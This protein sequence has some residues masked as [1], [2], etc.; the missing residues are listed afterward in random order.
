MPRHYPAELRRRTCERMLAGAAVKDLVEELGI[1]PK[2]LYRWR[3]QA[4]IDAGRDGERRASRP[5]RSSK[6]AAAS[7]NSRPS[8][9][10]SG[11]PAPC[12]RRAVGTQKEVPGCPRAEQPGLLRTPGLPDR[13]SGR[14]SY[15]EIKYRMPTSEIRRLL[16]SDAIADIHARSRGTYGMLRI[17]AALEIEQRLIVNKK[18]VW[19]IMRQ[20]GIHGLPGPKRG[21]EPEERPHL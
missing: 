14:S 21:Q 10:W 5:I 18:L 4:L 15:Y 16:L 19:K 13:R 3:R 2:T 9:R 12:S 8:S 17:R 6:P 1:A 11:R 20:L 7:K